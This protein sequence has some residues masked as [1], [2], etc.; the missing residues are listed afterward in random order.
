[1]QMRQFTQMDELNKFLAEKQEDQSVFIKS[2]KTLCIKDVANF[3][4]L[5]DEKA[6]NGQSYRPKRY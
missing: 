1:M 2:V 5:L 3:F 6:F 4:V